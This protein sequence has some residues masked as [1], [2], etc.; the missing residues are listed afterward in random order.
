MVGT[1]KCPVEY[2]QSAA[3]RS[4]A[5]KAVRRNEYRKALSVLCRGTSVFYDTNTLS[6]LMQLTVEFIDRKVMC[7]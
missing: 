4:S 7:R 5:D 1:T 3:T 6:A 2:A